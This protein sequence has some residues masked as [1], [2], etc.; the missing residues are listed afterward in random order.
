MLVASRVA[1]HHSEFCVSGPFSAL[2]AL[3]TRPFILPA[4]VTGKLVHPRRFT[5][6]K[7]RLGQVSMI[8]TSMA[9]AVVLVTFQSKTA[10]GY[11]LSL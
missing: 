4:T 10:T 2:T 8:D 3:R 9:C 7:C 11:E 1:M 5:P 6:G